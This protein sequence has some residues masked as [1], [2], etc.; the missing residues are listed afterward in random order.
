MRED[1]EVVETWYLMGWLHCLTHDHTPARF[2]LERTEEA[3]LHVMA[4]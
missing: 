2:Y 1:E 3:R 4:A